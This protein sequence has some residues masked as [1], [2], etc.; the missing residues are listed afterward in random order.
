MF[1][2]EVPIIFLGTEGFSLRRDGRY[3]RC[4]QSLHT[5]HSVFELA[6]PHPDY[7]HHAKSFLMLIARG[8]FLRALLS[9]LFLDLARLCKFCRRVLSLDRIVL[10]CS[11]SWRLGRRSS[12]ETIKWYLFASCGDEGASRVSPLNTWASVVF[13][14]SLRASSSFIKQSMV[15]S[16]LA[17]NVPNILTKFYCLY[18]LRYSERKEGS[19]SIYIPMSRPLSEIWITRI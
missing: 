3:G 11:H 5:F 14:Y 16:P 9:L 19:P 8:A 2:V 15:R 18:R 10:V 4:A 13:I 12:V 1:K 17:N 7:P 6:E